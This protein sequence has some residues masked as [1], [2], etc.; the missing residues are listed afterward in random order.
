MRSIGHILKTYWKQF[1]S[2][3]G[4]ELRNIFTDAG[5]LLVVVLAIFIYTTIYSCAYGSQVLRNVPL[6]VVDMDRTPESRALI[7]TFSSGPN[8]VVA[9]E[10]T[11]MA[12]AEEMFFAR[13]IYGIVYI[14]SDYSKNLY[15]GMQANVSLYLDGSYLLMYRQAFQELVAGIGTTG[16]MVEVQRL[17]SKGTNAQITKS[18]VQPIIYQTHNMFNPYLGYGS[19]VMPAIIIVIIQQTLL[20]GIGM[21]G[22]TW[23]EYG[24][25]DKLRPAGERRMATL[26][27]VMGKATAYAMIY[28]V[29]LF[30]ILNLLYR[31]FGFPMNGHTSDIIAFMIPY[32]LACIFLSI[33]VSTLFR[34]R[35]SSLLLLLWTSIPI[36]LLSGV[37]YPREAIP[38][39]LYAIGKIFPSSSG[40]E[41]FIRLQTMGASYIDVMPQ[42]RLLWILTIVYAG[43]ACIGIH[44]V[45]TS[46]LNNRIKERVK[47]RMASL[48]NKIEILR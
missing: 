46:N 17:I 40:V 36:L 7:N 22:G 23:R 19:F 45:T 12:E 3:I 29:T 48:K 25:Y 14:P 44:M 43:L 47:L 39:W 38:D 34:S 5:V 9:Y 2:V 18:T 41:G 33:A 28:T 8:T 10:P 42:V 6:G 16:A 21:L 11:S 26:P 20:I 35:E 24:L 1:V 4:N 13:K 37:S 27:I 30:V 31:I 15:G 32:L